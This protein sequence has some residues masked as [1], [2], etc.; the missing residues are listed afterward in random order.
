MTLCHMTVTPPAPKAPP[1]DPVEL[2]RTIGAALSAVR[3]Q[4]ADAGEPYATAISR[5]EEAVEFDLWPDDLLSLAGRIRRQARTDA[6][7]AAAELLSAVWWLGYAGRCADAEYDPWSSYRPEEADGNRRTALFKA[8]MA[9]RFA[10]A[11]PW[12]GEEV[13]S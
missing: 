7:I 2:W 5:A 9:L 10:G 13:A 4:L 6:Q 12:P 8:R 3:E 1:V 11:L